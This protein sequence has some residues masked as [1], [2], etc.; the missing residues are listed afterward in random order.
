LHVFTDGACYANGTPKALAGYGVH[1][2]HEEYDDISEAFTFKPHTNQRAELYAI[3]HALTISMND[4]EIDDVFV[5]TDSDYSIKCITR[6]A[7]GWQKAKWT[8]K[9]GGPLKN[10]DIIRPLYRLYSY[11]RDRVHFIHVR[12]HTGGTDDW[13]VGND[14]ADKLA[15]QGALSLLTGEEREAYLKSLKPKKKKRKRK[16]E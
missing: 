3:Y 13:S 11:N 10:L 7:P 12:S 15:G 8:R 4:K 5:Y 14:K 6:W 16:D 2:P 9:T 1:F